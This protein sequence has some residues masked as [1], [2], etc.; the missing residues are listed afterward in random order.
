MWGRLIE[1]TGFGNGRGHLSYNKM[2]T[3]TAL[4]LFGYA[5]ITRREPTWAL[6]SFGVV[7]IGAGFGLKGFLGAVKQNTMTA[8]TTVTA[9]LTKMTEIIT[10][11]DEKRGIDPA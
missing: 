7:V 8:Q 6:L 1:A 2:V 9:D 5:V 4:W 11:R 10:N 3:F